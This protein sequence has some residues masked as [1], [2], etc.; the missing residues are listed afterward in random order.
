MEASQSMAFALVYI[1]WGIITVILVVL[2]SYRAT[3]WPDDELISI[4][5]PDLERFKRQQTLLSKRSMLL[6][7]IVVLS[8]ISGVL[9]LTC[10]GFSLFRGH[11]SF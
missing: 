11:S 10:V 8:V 3:L 4:D 6:G 7:E 5:A 2:L 9:L 1:S